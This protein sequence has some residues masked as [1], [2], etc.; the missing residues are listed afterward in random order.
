LIA[1]KEDPEQVIEARPEAQVA[2]C[3]AHRVGEPTVLGWVVVL[4]SGDFTDLV[5]THTRSYHCT[6]GKENNQAT[7]WDFIIKDWD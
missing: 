2:A 3:R 4:I 1:L 5:K 7:P 6:P